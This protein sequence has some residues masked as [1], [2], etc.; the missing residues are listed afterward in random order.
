MELK[1]PTYFT[2]K[3][4]QHYIPKF[5]LRNFS[6]QKNGK[7]IGLFN[8]KADKYFQTGKL[9][10]QGS[11]SFFYGY[12]GIVEDTLSEIEG[13]IAKTIQD[14]ISTQTLPQRDTFEHGNLL[15]FV[16]LTHL[17]NPVII[18]TIKEQPKHFEKLMNEDLPDSVKKFTSPE[19]T[20]EYAIGLALS[21]LP[22]VVEMLHDLEYKILINDTSTCFITSDFPVVKYNQFLESKRWP[23][24]KTGYGNVGLQIFIPLNPRIVLVLYDPWIYKVG[25]KKNHKFMITQ[26]NDIR[27]INTLQLLNCYESIFFNEDI[28][29]NYARA[30]VHRTKGYVKPNQV[31]SSLAYLKSSKNPSPKQKNLIIVGS[32]DIEIKLNI[33]GIN[34]HSK[35][36]TYV[37]SSSVAQ[38]RPLAREVV[39]RRG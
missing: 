4:N 7:Q 28:N 27:Q 35:S 39:K 38:L 1:E 21:M 25:D 11:K 10:T 19:I 20:H 36:K 31:Q 18:D 6:Y 23:H 3:K 22:N 26:T 8:I 2:D 34:L 30:M 17:R 37:F 33:T 16:A 29:E 5:Y 9:K 32:T 15:V 24:G 12:D 13:E 14:I